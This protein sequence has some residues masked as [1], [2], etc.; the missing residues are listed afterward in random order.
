MSVDPT[1]FAMTIG[2]A[3][4]EDDSIFTCRVFD[5]NALHNVE[6]QIKLDLFGKLKRE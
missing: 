5:K 2:R 3:Q 1:T 6:G 4:L